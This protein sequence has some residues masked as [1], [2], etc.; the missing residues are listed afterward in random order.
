MF[1]SLSSNFIVSGLKKKGKWKK[2]KK[3]K[4]E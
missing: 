4:N 3:L 2:T 1:K